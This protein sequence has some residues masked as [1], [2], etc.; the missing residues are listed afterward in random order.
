ME[1][2]DLE[3]R[4]ET[5]AL[6]PFGEQ[7]FVRP[8]DVDR[9]TDEMLAPRVP[10]DQLV[11]FPTPPVARQ[12]NIQTRSGARYRIYEKRVSPVVENP[13]GCLHAHGVQFRGPSVVRG[14][15]L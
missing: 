8:H 14:R 1:V 4:D 11:L 7:R 2:V 5:G 9:P 6:N 3:Y 12:F 15:I 13:G 10:P